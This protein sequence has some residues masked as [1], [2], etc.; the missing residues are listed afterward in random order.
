[1]TAEVPDKFAP[2]GLTVT[3]G[4]WLGHEEHK[5]NY[6]D[7]KMVREQFEKA[8]E[9]VQKYK[10]NP[11]VLMWAVGNEMEGYKDGDNPAIWGAVGCVRSCSP[12][13]TRS[14][15]RSRGRMPAR[16]PTRRRPCPTRRCPANHP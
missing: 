2:L 11:A 3:V 4:I 10:D 1:M 13:E 8:K 12:R 14:R 16:R 7:P 9:A 5:F 15:T 6:N